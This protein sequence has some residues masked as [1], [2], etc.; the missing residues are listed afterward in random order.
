MAKRNKRNPQYP[1]ARSHYDAVSQPRPAA[2]TAPAP[3]PIVEP[4]V[5]AYV[6]Y[7]S[8][9]NLEKVLKGAEYT[10]SR[11]IAALKA[12]DPHDDAYLSAIPGLKNA[13]GHLCGILSTYFTCTT[14]ETERD[15]VKKRLAEI[16]SEISEIFIVLTAIER[17]KVEIENDIPAA[18][19]YASAHGKLGWGVARVDQTL[20]RIE[21][22][23]SEIERRKAKNNAKS[24][25]DASY[26]LAKHRK[27][28]P[29]GFRPASPYYPKLPPKGERVPDLPKGFRIIRSLP[30]EAMALNDQKFLVPK[31]GTRDEFGVDL[32]NLVT[33]DEGRMEMTFRYGNDPPETYPMA[34][35]GDPNREYPPLLLELYGRLMEQD[36]NDN[37]Q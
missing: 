24:E 13:F 14:I 4:S 7:G 30:E 26:S 17:E 5:D 31:P 28:D 37:G 25:R 19:R 20:Y 2:Q 9:E 1:P 23:P 6:Y 10:Y 33:Y 27:L 32:T 8:T 12:M 35:L 22:M 15:A 16:R 3:E 18:D 11:R 21:N 34:I 29:Q 36:L